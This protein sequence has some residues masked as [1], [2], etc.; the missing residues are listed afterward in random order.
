MKRMKRKKRI[1]NCFQ[2][3][4]S[5]SFSKEE[6]KTKETK[7]I[8]KKTQK[9]KEPKKKT[10]RRTKEKEERERKKKGNLVNQIQFN[11]F[12]NHLNFTKNPSKLH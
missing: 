10:K 7:E 3:L 2:N 4:G 8:K 1:G 11:E 12:A 9:I 6:R 5:L